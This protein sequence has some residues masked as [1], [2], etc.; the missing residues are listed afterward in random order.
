MNDSREATWFFGDLSDPWVTAIADA[1]PAA[2]G[3][4]RIDCPRDL[5]A[6]AF[7]AD[8]PPQLI[9][10]HRQRLAAVD[11]DRLKEWRALG[12]SESTPSLIL[13]VGPYVRYEELE[14][15]SGLVDLVLSE[16]TAADVLPRHAARLLSGRQGRQ[17][18]TGE[19]VH[20][21]L[22][23]ASSSGELCRT[24]AEACSVAGYRV[25]LTDDQFVGASFAH[26]E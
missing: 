12:N 2:P 26:A 15:H 7:A 9:V 20:L 4:A 6:Q 25:E 17:P 5:P 16:A 21:R 18:R 8:G 14:R 3:V 19:A 11:A 1:L 10:V 24:V 13:C 23:V 22:V